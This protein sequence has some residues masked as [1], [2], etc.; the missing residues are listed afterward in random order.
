MRS[1]CC[2]ISAV[3]PCIRP[4]PPGHAPSW[5]PAGTTPCTGLGSPRCCP[6]FFGGK[7]RGKES[8]GAPGLQH[9]LL[10]SEGLEQPQPAWG[11]L[12]TSHSQAS[13]EPRPSVTTATG[14]QKQGRCCRDPAAFAEPLPGPLHIPRERLLCVL[15]ER[16]AALQSALGSVYWDPVPEIHPLGSSPWDPS[17]GIHPLGSSPLS[18]AGQ[19][20]RSP[21]PVPACAQERAHGGACGGTSALPISPGGLLGGCTILSC[22]QQLPNPRD[23]HS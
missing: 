7:K 18:M 9:P 1:R 14:T 10:R 16:C 15:Q 4:G 3:S 12:C 21:Q 6:L 20:K 23:S 2:C 17:S 13:P 19:G 11:C 5:D 8:R 22:A